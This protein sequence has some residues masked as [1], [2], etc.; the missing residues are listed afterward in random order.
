MITSID[1][2]RILRDQQKRAKKTKSGFDDALK[3]LG[4]V[5]QNVAPKKK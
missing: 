1:I 2:A 5:L 4:V 3:G